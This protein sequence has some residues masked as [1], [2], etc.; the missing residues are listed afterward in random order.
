[1][2]LAFHVKPIC[3]YQISDVRSIEKTV[4]SRPLIF[5]TVFDETPSSTSE[6]P[7]KPSKQLFN[8]FFSP[9]TTEKP[10]D[11][12]HEEISTILEPTNTRL[13]PSEGLHINLFTLPT[14]SLNYNFLLNQQDTVGLDHNLEEQT[15]KTENSQNT[16]GIRPSVIQNEPLEGNDDID[17]LKERKPTETHVKKEVHY[18]QHKHF[19]GYI[20]KQKQEKVPANVHEHSHEHKENKDHHHH[21]QEYDIEIPEENHKHK[22][23]GFLRTKHK[24]EH[25]HK[26]QRENEQVP[27]DVLE[28]SHAQIHHH[29]EYQGG[30]ESDDK[31]EYEDVL[32]RGYK[33]KDKREYSH[34]HKYENAH[35]HQLEPEHQL[36]DDPEHYHTNKEKQE[37]HHSDYEED[38]KREHSHIQEH[39]NEHAHQHHR[40]N[41]KYRRE[42][43]KQHPRSRHKIS[44]NRRVNKKNIDQN[45]EKQS[46]RR[47]PHQKQRSHQQKV[48]VKRY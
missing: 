22:N 2:T 39:S 14:D 15:P 48:I 21:N 8:Q 46:H 6:I 10:P 20:T 45:R 27:I 44:H 23:R 25:Y 37:H 24:N 12:P 7:F 13:Q 34:K 41:Q 17:E 43:N 16:K 3:S 1:M 26:L 4:T 33:Q 31:H 47:R 11:P 36:A 28:H 29:Q 30:P 18:H 19:H 32:P 38:Y 42:G 40:G 5:G 9:L 35:Y